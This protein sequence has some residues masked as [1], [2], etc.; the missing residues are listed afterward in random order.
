MNTRQSTHSEIQKRKQGPWLDE[1]DLGVRT[2]GSLQPW[3]VGAESRNTPAYRRR[4]LPAFR[5]ADPR[6][7]SHYLPTVTNQALHIAKMH[8][9]RLQLRCRYMIVNV[10]KML[11]PA[12]DI[13]TV[14]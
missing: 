12:L 14:F 7:L 10:R 11:A 9:K 8:L 3:T 2:C 4:C 1:S 13:Q 5:I 6:S